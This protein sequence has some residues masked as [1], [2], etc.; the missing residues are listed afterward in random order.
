MAL[1][2]EFLRTLPAGGAVCPCCLRFA[3]VYRYKI[4]SGM[5][6]CLIW[7]VGQGPKYADVGGWVHLPEKAPR[8]V[9]TSNSI[10][11]LKYWGLVEAKFNEDSRKKESGIWRPTQDGLRFVRRQ[12]T[13][14]S[15]A[16]VYNDE[17]LR[18]DGEGIE[19]KTA[20]K[21]PFDYE[22]LMA[23]VD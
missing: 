13:V 12:Q 18:F 22:K 16:V 21:N 23:G 8:H 14:H 10:G 11:K 6:R 17:L 5:A 1:D 7:L 20:L 15:H 19:I 9:L 4:T 2:T 3:K